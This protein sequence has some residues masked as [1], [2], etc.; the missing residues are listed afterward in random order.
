MTEALKKNWVISFKY[1]KPNDDITEPLNTLSK[2]F[3][4]PEK[5]EVENFTGGGNF[6]AFKRF[7]PKQYK[8]AFYEAAR[9]IVR[10]GNWAADQEIVEDDENERTI[11]TFTSAQDMG[12]L[13][14]VFEN[15]AYALPLEPPSLVARWRYNVAEMARMAG[16]DVQHDVDIEEVNRMDREEWSSTSSYFAPIFPI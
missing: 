7:R 10:S 15:K 12:I 4:L 2:H 14:W 5:F 16:Y 13:D 9:P 3:D 1:P 11:I 8:I 6:G